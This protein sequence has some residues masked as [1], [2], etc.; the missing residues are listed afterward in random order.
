MSCQS[1]YL[2]GGTILPS[3][4]TVGPAAT[5]TRSLN[6]VQGF[7]STCVVRVRMRRVCLVPG[8]VRVVRACRVC[9]HVCVASAGYW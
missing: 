1:P 6:G 7:I 8:G 9:V 4:P 5:H 2:G 3:D